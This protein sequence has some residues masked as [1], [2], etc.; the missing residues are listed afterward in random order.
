MVS[1]GV[2]IVV[3][4]LADSSIVYQI[5]HHPLNTKKSSE[6]ANK[7]ST[8]TA[9]TIPYFSWGTTTGCA[10]ATLAGENAHIGPDYMAKYGKT[11]AFRGGNRNR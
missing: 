4:A 3:L 10:S 11:L 2:T 8:P 1:S 5:L 9:I 6:S 7:N